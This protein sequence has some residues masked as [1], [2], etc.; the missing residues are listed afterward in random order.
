MA[1][2]APR[3]SRPFLEKN[4]LHV[5]FIRLKSIFGVVAGFRRKRWCAW[6][7]VS[8]P[9]GNHLPLR[10]ILRGPEFSSCV[11]RVS[12]DL[13]RQRVQEQTA[14]H[15]LIGRH[16]FGDNFK[17]E[18]GLFLSPGESS[19]GQ[20]LQPQ[21][22]VHDRMTVVAAYIALAL[23]EENGLNSAAIC[24]EVQRRR[25]LNVLGICS[26]YSADFGRV[27]RFGAAWIPDTRARGEDQDHL[28][29]YSHRYLPEW[30]GKGW[31]VAELS[32]S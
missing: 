31:S 12:A 23:L 14:L 27:K 18:S 13:W 1:A 19:G 20:R 3:V 26:A 21:A 30:A 16:Q 28:Y 15:W 11:C 5:R 25:C 8:D 24:C 10:V 6:L 29:R 32:T 7:S 4:G 9:I 22:G 2:I 17:I